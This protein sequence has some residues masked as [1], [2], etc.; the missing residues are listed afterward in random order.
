MWFFFFFSFLFFNK[1]ERGA[2][3]QELVVNRTWRV[4][5]GFTGRNETLL[6]LKAEQG[7]LRLREP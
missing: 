5:E 6:R 4:Q 1:R 2:D 7:S 3:V